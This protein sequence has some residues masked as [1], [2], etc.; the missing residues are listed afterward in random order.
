MLRLK[1]AKHDEWIDNLSCRPWY[2][3]ESPGRNPLMS[4]NSKVILPRLLW[5]LG[6]VL[7]G[8]YAAWCHF[9]HDVIQGVANLLEIRVIKK[10]FISIFSRCVWMLETSYL[11][12]FPGY[13]EPSCS[14][15]SWM[16]LEIAKLISSFVIC[17][18][19]GLIR[20]PGFVATNAFRAHFQAS[21][22]PTAQFSFSQSMWQTC[23]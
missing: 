23:K 9:L 15:I 18:K 3:R 21:K 17:C 5:L 6:P 13:S 10:Y 20:L 14:W 7:S 4:N 12:D 2:L 11:S 8:T 16:N 19:E 1:H 22:V